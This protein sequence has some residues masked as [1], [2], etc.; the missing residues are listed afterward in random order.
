M[1]E[2]ADGPYAVALVDLA[3]GVRVMANVIDCA[4]DDVKVG[5]A[6]R[7]TWQERPDGRNLLQFEPA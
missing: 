6:V 1:R 3:E 2:A 5:M 4:P 7:A